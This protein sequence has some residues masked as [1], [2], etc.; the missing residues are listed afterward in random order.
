ML[1]IT[2]AA[3]SG[4]L[5]PCWRLTGAL[6]KKILKKLEVGEGVT[7]SLQS[8]SPLAYWRG[9]TVEEL[10]EQSEVKKTYRILPK[11]SSL[12]RNQEA[13]SL[14]DEILR[15]MF[16]KQSL[17]LPAENIIPL[18]KSIQQL[19]FDLLEEAEAQIGSLGKRSSNYPFRCTFAPTNVN[20]KFDSLRATTTNCT[21]DVR[22]FEPKFWN[23]D[24]VR[25]YNNCYT[26][27]YGR[28][29]G[30]FSW[31]GIGGAG[32]KLPGEFSLSL[33]KNYL[34]KDGLIP[35]HSCLDK[36]YQPRWEIGAYVL[37][38]PGSS[39]K[40]VDFHF[41]RRNLD[42]KR[43][44]F[45]SSKTGSG[46]AVRCD[47]RAKYILDPREAYFAGQWVFVGFYTLPVNYVRIGGF[48]P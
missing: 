27:A 18:S 37:K 14:S 19:S 11:I 8:E 47:H 13:L 23:Q 7:R 28:D 20:G 25:R 21:I 48:R 40:Y 5:P 3:F 38:S 29:L 4:R 36:R 24:S 44:T 33:F 17:H 30:V 32:L 43:T 45:W 1:R 9:I 39:N 12:K 2:I 41:V 6:A 34:S 16:V 46:Y 35:T 26:Y 15:T 10:D 31:P 42:Y 22:V